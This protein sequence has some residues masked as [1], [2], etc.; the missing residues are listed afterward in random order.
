MSCRRGGARAGTN[1][2]VGTALKHTG[3]VDRLKARGS[4]P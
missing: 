2:R 4:R 1:V 3:G